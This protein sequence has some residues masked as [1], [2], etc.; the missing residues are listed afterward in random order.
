[1]E[2]SQ[3]GTEAQAIARRLAFVEF[4]EL[5][6][7]SRLRFE[8]PETGASKTLIGTQEWLRRIE[9][10]A[11]D[12]SGV[13]VCTTLDALHAA[14][15]PPADTE[16]KI[17]MPSRGKVRLRALFRRR[18]SLAPQPCLRVDIQTLIRRVL[19][20]AGA[21]AHLYD[22]VR[23]VAMTRLWVDVSRL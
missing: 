4:M 21:P 8:Q 7:F 23:H 9:R 22:L 1:M 18:D 16:L 10:D 6:E 17:D 19:V 11:L 13:Y 5:L 12:T 15:L 3:H 14:V 2:R 20:P